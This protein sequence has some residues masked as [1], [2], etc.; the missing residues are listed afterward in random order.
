MIFNL[1]I[2]PNAAD[3]AKADKPIK[4]PG[5]TTVVQEPSTSNSKLGT[6]VVHPLSIQPGTYQDG[7]GQVKK[8]GSYSF[9]S[10]TIISIAR[11]KHIIET[12]V[13][14][15]DNSV[16]ELIAMNNHD[17]YITGKI[18]SDDNSYPTDKVAA[19]KKILEIPAALEVTGKKFNVFDIRR[20]IIRDWDFPA[21]EAN[22]AQQ[23]FSI[24]A[25]S[26]EDIILNL[27]KKQ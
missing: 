12:A 9:D 26:D 21:V 24:S 1:D 7:E 4:D 22:V 10:T 25:R 3:P 20:I 13:A 16:Q 6:P 18:I 15:H 27:N 11:S 23:P 2:F 14:G 8:Y 5:Q 17:I 19:L